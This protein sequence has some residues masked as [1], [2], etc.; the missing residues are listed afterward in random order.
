ME[1]HK[2]AGNNMYML[3]IRP[4]VIDQNSSHPALEVASENQEDL[5]DWQK[6]IEDACLAIQSHQHNMF[7]KTQ[8]LMQQSRS[9]KISLEMSDLVIYCQP[10]PFALESEFVSVREYDCV[11]VC[12][13]VCRVVF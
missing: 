7:V 11:C 4:K 1:T 9:R 8:V 3:S 10:V 5:M 12:V 2:K 6:Q 13:F